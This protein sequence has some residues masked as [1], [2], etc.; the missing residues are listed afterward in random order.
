MTQFAVRIG[1]ILLI[2]VAVTPVLAGPRGG[3]P[4][5][6]GGVHFGGGGGAPHFSRPHFS[7]PVPFI[8]PVGP[9][10][11]ARPGHLPQ[12]HITN[13]APRRWDQ[14]GRFLDPRI[15]LRTPLLFQASIGLARVKSFAIRS[16]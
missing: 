6:G 4:F 9:Q 15:K 8:T 13:W 10:R 16:S 3:A 11:F 2:C 1:S 14:C 5:L 7:A 12:S